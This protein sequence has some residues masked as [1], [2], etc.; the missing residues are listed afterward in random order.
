M[1]PERELVQQWLTKAEQD[2]RAAD[3]DLNVLD[4]AIPEDACFH[5]QQTTEKALKA[6]LVYRNVEFAWSHEIEYLLTLC[7]EQCESF[8]ELSPRRSSRGQVAPRG[9]GAAGKA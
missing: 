1:P 2:L 3:G 4:P 8:D 5:C 7:V 9:Q 6:Y